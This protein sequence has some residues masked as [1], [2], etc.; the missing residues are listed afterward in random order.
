MIIREVASFL[1]VFFIVPFGLGRAILPKRA[2]LLQGICGF[3][4]SLSL[5]EVLVLIFHAAGA[6]LR[7]MV[8]LWCVFCIPGTIYGWRN[9][10]ISVA[11]DTDSSSFCRRE[12][13]DVVEIALLIA[14]VLVVI[15]VT[16]NT[17]FNTTY[18]NW[19]DQTYCTNAVASWQSDLVNRLA[20]HSGTMRP[21]FYD[22]KYAIAGWPVYSSMLA[23]LSGI[24]PAIIFRTLLPLFEI[25]A[26]VGIVYLLLREFFSKSRKKALLGLLYYI[27]FALAVAEK[28]GGNCSEWWL[29]VNCWTGK[30]IAFNIVVPLVLWLMFQLEK[31]QDIKLRKALWITLFLVC[32]AACNIAATM[33]VILPIEIGIWG[34]FFLYRT[35]R[36]NEIGK[37]ALCAAPPTL[38]AMVTMF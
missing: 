23:V 13:M 10:K 31:E 30:A 14:A 2:R 8:L 20:P 37:F 11:S 26:A 4:A 32:G 36:W 28:M 12:K 15:I 25:P 7:L 19:D 21:A 34:I 22:K 33:F 29:F 16:L 6:S 3:S 35:K 38:C 24:H 1:A 9:W 27:F 18:V 17:V 5:F